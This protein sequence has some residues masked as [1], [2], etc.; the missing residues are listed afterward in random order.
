MTTSLRNIIIASAIAVT[1]T[2]AIAGTAA[3]TIAAN[4]AADGYTSVE[5]RTGMLRSRIEA[6]RG[7]EKLELVVDNSTGDVVKSETGA[8][9]DD[10][11]EH[12]KTG[13]NHQDRGHESHGEDHGDHGSD[14]DSGHDSGHDSD[15]GDGG[16]GGDSEGGHGE[17]GHGGY[18]D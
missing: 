10:E 8:A 3:D 12:H 15:H 7:S 17:G 4:L 13:E 18:H 14:H 16:H 6:I 1:G 9:D 11:G 2:C 5:V